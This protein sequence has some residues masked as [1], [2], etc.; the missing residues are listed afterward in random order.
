MSIQGKRLLILGGTTAT[1][2]LVKTAKEMGVYTIVADYLPEGVSKSVADES[3]LISTTDLD[4]LEKLMK[5]KKVD[6]VFCGPSEFNLRNLIALCEK[7]GYPCYTNMEVWDNCANKDT[8][9]K[10]CIE[11][12]VDCPMEF[13]VDEN[14]SE[15]E[16][17]A[18]DYPVIVKPVDG[19][20]SAGI[21]VCSDKSTLRDACR[22][23]RE[24][25]A[26]KCIIVEKYIENGGEL[27]VPMYVIKNGDV[28][29]YLLLDTYV[30]NPDSR[31]SLIS[32][33]MYAPS[34]YKDYYMENMDSKVRTMLKN[35]GIKNGVAFFQS[36]PCDGKIYFHEMGYRLGGGFLFKMTRAM[37]GISDMEMMLRYA[38]GEDVY[39]ESYMANADAVNCNGK[40]GA[41]LTVPLNEGTVSSIEGLENLLSLPTLEDFIQYYHIGDTILPKH[42]GTLSQHFGR[43]T[44]VS[45]SRKELLDSVRQITNN[46]VI[47][48]TD[49]NIMNTMHFDL[50][51]I[52]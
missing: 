43:F 8:F 34:K 19:S 45:E 13:L 23:A 25:S 49:G 32:H 27:F 7:T 48:D 15:D 42:I 26:R 50:S 51:R 52:N 33:F 36:L 6:G 1:L 31:K 14:S 47:K 21:T 2:D 20:S 38:L 37:M 3:A 18:V 12:G 29:P 11:N 16:L 39:E 46:L 41:Q 44:L 35:M 28:R 40:F 24:N 17:D 30:A 22:F 5:E 4:G 10:Y 9:K